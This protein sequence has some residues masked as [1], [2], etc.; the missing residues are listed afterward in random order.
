M[1]AIA[2]K[3][4]TLLDVGLGYIKL[5]QSATTLSGG[6]AQR[7]KLSLE[8]SKRDTGRTLYILDEP[9][10]GLHFHDIDLLLTVLHRL[11]DH[12]NTVVVI[13]HNLDVIKTA[14]WVIDLGPEGGDGG[15]RIIAQGTPEDVAHSAGELHR[16]VPEGDPRA[17]AAAAHGR[18]LT[19]MDPRELLARE[20]PRGA[21]RRR[22]ARHR[23]R[24]TCR[25]RRAGARVVV[26]AGKAAASM[27]L[28]VEQHW[29]ADAPL[30][31]TRHHALRPRPAAQAHPRRRGRPSGARRAGRGGGARDP[32]PRA[33]ARRKTTCCSCWSRAADRRC[34]RCPSDG[35]PMADLKAVTR[36][37][38]ACGAPIQDMN[39]VRKHLSAIQGGRLAAATTA[40]V[41]ALVISDVTG[42][43]PTHIASGPCAPDPT[44]YRDALDILARYG[45]TP[46]DSIARASANAERE[47]GVPETPKPGDAALRARREPRDRHR[48]REPRAGRGIRAAARRRR[49]W[50]SATA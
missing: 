37:L 26:G 7:V 20:L 48:A 9:T 13:E 12:G 4:Q 23:P 42:D 29:P 27:A 33:L 16:Q 49:R 31:G 15:G 3:L 45:V 25:R 30:E 35:C 32:R 46:P 17:P 14:D 11:R 2:R 34:C 39:T 41:L 43:D 5:G 50:C 10:T 38:L 18:G 36:D 47:G 8:L 21:R 28:A 44:T 1:P 6:E 22:S 40:R 19:A 24:S